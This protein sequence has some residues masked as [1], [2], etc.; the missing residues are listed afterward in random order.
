MIRTVMKATQ[1]SGQDTHTR[2]M[3]ISLPAEPFA[4]PSATSDETAPTLPMI[5]GD[6]DWRADRE[7]GLALWRAGR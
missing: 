7:L 1:N 4:V 6:R 2:P 5:R 3:A